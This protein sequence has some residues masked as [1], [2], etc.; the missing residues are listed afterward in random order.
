MASGKHGAAADENRR[1]IEACRRH[2][3]SGYNL[4]AVRN[5]NK[6]IES[7]RHGNSL[8]GVRDQFTTCE[9]VF[10]PR[11]PHGNSVADTDGRKLNRRS[12]CG[13]YTKF[14]GF[15]NCV[16]MKMSRNN[17]I[18]RV[19]DTDQWFFK[20]LRTIS[21]CMKKRAMCTACCSLFYN[22]TSHKNSPNLL[23]FMKDTRI[24]KQRHNLQRHDRDFSAFHYFFQ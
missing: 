20:I 2:E 10:H 13:S 22:I 19:A 15:C 17:L 14:D 21:V 8:D 11:M 5:E 23:L 24:H 3:H 6:S 1:N 16:Q 9:R 4:I 12:T 18:K 7:R